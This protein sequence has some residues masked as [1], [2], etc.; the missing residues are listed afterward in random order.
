MTQSVALFSFFMTSQYICTKVKVI[1]V[2]VALCFGIIGYLV[3]EAMLRVKEK[4]DM[5]AIVVVSEIS[6]KSKQDEAK[7]G[8]VV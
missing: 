5:K 3:L 7:N 1:A 8:N 6:V 4:K 2:L